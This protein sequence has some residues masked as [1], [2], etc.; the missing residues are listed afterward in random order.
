VSPGGKPKIHGKM[1]KAESFW[2][3]C[4]D[5]CIVHTD[6]ATEGPLAPPSDAAA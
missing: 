1:G 5:K 3:D 4:G 6:I 2:C